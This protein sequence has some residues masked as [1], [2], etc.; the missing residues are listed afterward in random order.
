M[1]QPAKLAPLLRAA[2]ADKKIIGDLHTTF[3]LDVGTPERLNE[4]HT[5]LS[6]MQASVPPPAFTPTA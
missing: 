6:T 5:R 2:M 4:L 1:G 3:W